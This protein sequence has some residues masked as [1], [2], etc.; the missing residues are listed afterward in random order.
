MGEKGFK[1]DLFGE[2]ICKQIKET[3]RRVI[4]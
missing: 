2:A 4:C 1:T 3:Q